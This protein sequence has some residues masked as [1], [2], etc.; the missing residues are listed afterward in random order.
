MRVYAL[1]DPHLAFSTA[2]KSMEVFGPAWK[3]YTQ[4]IEENWLKTIQPEDL[5]LIA[6]DIFLGDEF[7]GCA[8]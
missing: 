2:D 8:R 4:K 6:G 3:D 7:S 1:S 5:V